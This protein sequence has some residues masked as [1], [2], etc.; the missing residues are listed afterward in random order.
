MTTYLFTL[1]EGAGLVGPETAVAGRLVARGHRVEFIGDPSTEAAVRAVGA[2]F[3]TWTT[4]THRASARPEDDLAKDWEASSPLELMRRARDHNFLGPAPGL[5]RDTAAAI[6]DVRP[7]V[8]VCDGYHLGPQVAGLAAGLPTASLIPHPYPFPAAGIPPTGTGW[9]L[10]RGP[11]GRARDRLVLRLLDRFWDARLDDLNAVRAE[12]GLPP[13]GRVWDLP[14]SLDRQ[15]VL[16]SAAFDFPGDLPANVVYT[17]PELDDPH[18][19][20]EWEPPRGDGPLVLVGLSSGYMAQEDLLRRILGALAELGTRAVVTTGPAIDP[21]DFDA[22]PGVQLV[23]AA[24]HR[25][26]LTE[27]DAVIGHGGHGTTIKAVAAGVPQV[28]IPLGRDQ[29]DNGAR[30]ERLGAGIRLSSG[31]SAG[32]IAAATRR[33]LSGGFSERAREAGR[34]VMAD[35][36]PSAAVRELEAMAAVGESETVRPSPAP[37]QVEPG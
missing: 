19:A 15:L 29:A 32:K 4:A 27:A 18:W 5:A 7:D 26:A 23:R 21:H 24:S 16:T 17:G 1:W 2:G 14:P 9:A 11:A 12:L 20:G 34:R 6:A 10:A 37:T 8:V 35:H 30:V 28:V 22:P 3:R 13:Q 36:D 25:R 31:A 33:V